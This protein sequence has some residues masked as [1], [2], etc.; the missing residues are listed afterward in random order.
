MYQTTA[1][2][3]TAPNKAISTSFRFGQLANASVRGA[4]DVVP[5]AFICRNTGLSS[6]CIRIHIETARRISESRKGRRQPQAANASSPIQRARGDDDDQS[7][8]EANRRGG[9]DETRVET[10][11]IVRRMLGDIGRGSAILAAER[12]TLQ[13]AERDEQDGCG[14][15]DACV[16]GK[17]AD[18][19]GRQAHDGHGDEEGVLPPDQIADAA[20]DDCPERTDCEACREGRES[21]DEVRSSR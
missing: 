21:E 20:E 19:E 8:E 13:D 10:A 14:D 4:F 5:S 7:R 17:Q 9:L 1:W 11:L 18:E 16:I 6:S 15:A 3:A 2:P 12:Q